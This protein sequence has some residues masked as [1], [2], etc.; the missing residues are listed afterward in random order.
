MNPGAIPDGVTVHEEVLP[1]G[2]SDSSDES[3]LDLGMIGIVVGIVVVFGVV[4]CLLLKR[5]N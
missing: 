4:A 1:G 3:E 2:P 5:R